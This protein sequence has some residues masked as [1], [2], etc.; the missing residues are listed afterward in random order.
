MHTPLAQDILLFSTADW[1]NPFWTNKQ[2]M[3]SLFAKRGY[4]VLYVDSLG[5]RRPSLQKRDMHRIWRR[6]RKALPVPKRIRSNLWRVS[7]LVFPLHSN[8]LIR[9]CNAALLQATM[10]WHMGLLGMKQPLIWTYNPVIADLCAALPNSGIV[11][12]C[13]DDLSASPQIDAVVIRDAEKR[14]AEVADICFTT[15]HALTEKMSR[16]FAKVVYEPNVCDQEFFATAHTPLPQPPELE[17]IPHPRLI[18]IGALSQY[19]VDFSL[20]ERLAERLPDAHWVLIGSVGEGQPGSQGPPHLPNIH[21]LGPIPYARL[22]QFMANCDV[23]A[24]PVNHNAY[25]DAMFPMK[26]FESL[27]GG[28]PVVCTRL[29]ALADFETLYFA[30]GDGEE[31]YSLLQKVLSGEQRDQEAIDNAC[32]TYSWEARLTRMENALKTLPGA[33]Q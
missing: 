8:E 33:P 14:L 13:V 16:I 15:S 4:R 27:S 10:R 17:G 31:F 21:T 2:H 24:M 7:P 28:L 3:A 26:F 11:Y 18:F 32:R 25:T 5:L 19:K 30:A 1:D 6:L 23:A 12:H 22:P 9:K 20:M 29:P